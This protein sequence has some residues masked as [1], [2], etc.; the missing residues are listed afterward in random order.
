MP[1][2]P[3]LGAPGEQQGRLAIWN[4]ARGAPFTSVTMS[5]VP[6]RVCR[7]VVLGQK[8]HGRA[9]AGWM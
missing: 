6:P 9:S 1:E 3:A 8:E 4:L 5:M 7:V 2:D